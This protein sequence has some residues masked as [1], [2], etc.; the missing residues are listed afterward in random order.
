M[1]AFSLP[2]GFDHLHAADPFALPTSAAMRRRWWREGAGARHGNV[3]P[4]AG[5]G[6]GAGRRRS[7]RACRI[8]MCRGWRM[9]QE[10]GA[11]A[12]GRI[13]VLVVVKRGREGCTVEGAAVEGF[14]VAAPGLDRGGGPLLRGVGGAGAG[15]EHP[16][17]GPEGERRRGVER[18]RG[19]GRRRHSLDW[20]PMADWAVQ[21]RK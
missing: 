16:G 13:R 4:P 5:T 20:E 12:G 19:R 8:R 15:F 6:W 10:G 17:G 3:A 7:R 18:P 21:F 14:P 11:G 2:E 1:P 9:R